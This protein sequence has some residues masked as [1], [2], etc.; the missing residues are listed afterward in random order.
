MKHHKSR[1]HTLLSLNTPY[2]SSTPTQHV[3]PVPILPA[4]KLLE[5]ILMRELRLPRVITRIIPSAFFHAIGVVGDSVVDTTTAF[6]E[7]ESVYQYGE[8]QQE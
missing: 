2:I 7:E 4:I 1:S 3:P 6:E 8:E 5:R